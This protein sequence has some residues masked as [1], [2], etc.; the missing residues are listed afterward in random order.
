MLGIL[1]LAIIG[2][3]LFVWF[4]P[5]TPATF[6]DGG[7]ALPAQRGRTYRWNFDDLPIGNPPSDFA[8]ALG[9][10]KVELE[11]SAPSRPHVLRQVGRFAN[12]DFPRI[13]VRQLTFADLT[14]RV[15]CRPEAG[16]LDRSCGLMF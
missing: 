11:D 12:P 16:W 7:V 14:L 13:L 5:P 8:V 2:G 10:W 15:H 1:L 4:R 9:F 6:T 3:A